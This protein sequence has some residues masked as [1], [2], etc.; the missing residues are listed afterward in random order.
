MVPLTRAASGEVET[1]EG[2]GRGLLKRLR[3]TKKPPPSRAPNFRRELAKA[4]RADAS[5]RAVSF[6]SLVDFAAL[7]AVHKGEAIRKLAHAAAEGALDEVRLDNV[8]LDIACAESLVTLLKVPRLRVLSVLDNRLNEAAVQRLARCLRAHP[9]IRELAIGDQHNTP[10]STYA[11]AELLDA[12]ETTPTLV[13]LRLGTVHDDALRRRYLRLETAHVEGQRKLLR[14]GRVSASAS[15]PADECDQRAQRLREQL[16][17]LESLKL[18]RDAGEPLTAEE[19]ELLLSKEAERL[20]REE[21]TQLREEAT[22][23]A[24][25]TPPPKPPPK[26]VETVWTVEAR[27]IGASEEAAFGKP[28]DEE[29]VED[30]EEGVRPGGGRGGRTGGAKRP[31]KDPATHYILTGSPEW[32]SATKVERRAVIEAFATNTHFTNV[33][34]SD[35]MID[36]DL[37]RS[38]ATVLACPTCVIESLT[39]ESNPIGS[40]GIE[41]LASALPSNPSLRELRLR[42]LLGRVS[43]EAEETFAR[44][45]ESH[46][47]LTKLPFDLK[48]YKA[49]DMMAKFLERN[50][51][52]RWEAKG[53]SS[54]TKE[55][56]SQREATW[57]P[58]VSPAT[59]LPRIDAQR[60]GGKHVA[61]A[62]QLWD[63]WFGRG[64]KYEEAESDGRDGGTEGDRS[65]AAVLFDPVELPAVPAELLTASSVHDGHS[66]SGLLPFLGLGDLTKSIQQKANELMGRRADNGRIDGSPAAA[67]GVGEGE[68]KKKVNLPVNPIADEVAHAALEHDEN[69]HLQV[70]K[71]EERKSLHD[72][73][74]A[75]QHEAHHKLAYVLEH[76]GELLAA[77]GHSDADVI[78]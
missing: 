30:V 53:W 40:A 29:A 16:E 76:T 57:K 70:A 68:K 32:R 74:E 60:R 26:P 37:A 24:G 48:S 18:R 77:P 27:R 23:K 56:M 46:A 45:L 62:A 58:A 3:G 78:A 36:D 66:T 64:G 50:E 1:A 41:A 19:M 2:E 9:N 65:A 61:L 11:V 33:C 69:V 25:A 63:G 6:S 31:Y 28:A 7:S 42:N 75:E 47:L 4:E 17:Q 21:I 13:R 71:L 8:G 15:T 49:R 22:A 54:S 52:R 10:L 39:L 5:L 59:K 34:M 44:A 67:P 72:R 35:S 20:L 14:S 73:E 12:M 51:L 55:R 38:W 43:K